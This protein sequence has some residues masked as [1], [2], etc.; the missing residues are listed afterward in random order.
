MSTWLLCMCLLW[1]LSP[2]STS[3][4]STS[5]RLIAAVLGL[6][7]LGMSNLFGNGPQPLLWTDSQSASVRITASGI[8]NCPKHG[9]LFI[10]TEESVYNDNG[11]YSTLL[12]ASDILWY[13]LIPP[14]NHNTVLLSYNST[15]LYQHKIFIPFHEVITR[16]SYIYIIFQMSLQ[17]T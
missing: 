7:R 8:L 11:L 15:H 16:F 14:V 13:E 3:T 10:S 2:H 1:P 12:I 9:V 4:L 6:P 17:A 5:L